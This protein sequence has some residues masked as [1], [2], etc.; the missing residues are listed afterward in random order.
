[1][2]T[3]SGFRL[4]YVTAKNQAEAT[5]LAE[6]MVKE[7][8]AACANLIPGMEAIYF[9][10][11]KICR[12]HEIVVIAKTTEALVPAL[13]DRIKQLHS[14]KTPCIISLPITQ[15]NPAFLSWIADETKKAPV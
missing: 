9:W 7:R 12:D 5:S 10:D 15:G 2:M 13:I 8:L 4:V 1:M 3:D 6:A 14:Y 11:G